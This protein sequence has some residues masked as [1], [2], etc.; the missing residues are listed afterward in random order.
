MLSNEEI[1]SIMDKVMS[2][3]TADETEAYVG[4]HKS[5]LTRF[6]ENYIHQNVSQDN[7]YLSVSVI[8]NGRMG[9]ASTN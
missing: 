8:F 6:A 3:S 9:E 1:K 4:S 2:I 5:S 7:V